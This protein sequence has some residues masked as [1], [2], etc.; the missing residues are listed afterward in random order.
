MKLN[1]TAATND[2][3][4]V[5]ANLAFGGTLWLTNL[6]GP[7]VLNDSFKLFSASSYSG[8]FTNIFPAVPQPGLKWDVSMLG[9]NGIVRIVSAPPPSFASILVSGNR[10]ML[11]ATNGQPYETCWLLTST[12]ITLPLA[13]WAILTTNTFDS[14]GN[15]SFTNFNFTSV[16]Q[17][18]Y[19]LELR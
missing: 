11:S 13:S 7:L 19:R 12:N 9:S 5:G 8:A 4:Q 1:K 14:S 16:P 3:L 15:V 17:G 18:F 2:V 6:S 10:L